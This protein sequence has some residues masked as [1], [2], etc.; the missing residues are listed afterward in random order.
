MELADAGLDPPSGK[1]SVTTAAGTQ[2]VL[3]GAAIP[4]DPE[5]E[6]PADERYVAV[7]GQSLVWRLRASAVDAL[8]RSLD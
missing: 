5:A 6:R 2:V 7:E 1:A 8:V 3:L 4:E